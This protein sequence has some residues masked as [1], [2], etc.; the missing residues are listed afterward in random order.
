[1]LSRSEHPGAALRYKIHHGG[2]NPVAPYRV[3]NKSAMDALPQPT[4]LLPTWVPV[5]AGRLG[6]DHRPRQASFPLLKAAG[7][8]VVVTLLSAREGAEG[9]GVLTQQA[10]M[11][12]VWLALENGNLPQGE[13][14]QCLAAAVPELSARLDG[15][16]TLLIHC[17]AGI[18][19]TGMLAYGLL[20]WRGL[21]EAECLRI[22]TEARQVTAEG[23]VPKRKL[24]A[25]VLIGAQ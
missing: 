18:H 11:D 22:M 3:Y 25:D 17:S 13:A 8:D 21:A 7:C 14:H 6:L 4:I 15:G 24:W 1:M 16:Q 23:L 2:R 20:R 10:G 19:R 9:I 12:W 5:G